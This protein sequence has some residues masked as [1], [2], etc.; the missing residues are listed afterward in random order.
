MDYDL[1]FT[2]REKFNHLNSYLSD[3]TLD[4]VKAFHVTEQ[5]SYKALA[6]W[7][8]VYNN[9]S[10]IFWQL[11]NLSNMTKSQSTALKRMIDT[12]S[13]IYDTLLSI[14]DN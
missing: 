13:A 10:H 4:T 8:R 14:S 5:K 3:E 6:C 12:V 1:S 2:G 9:M 11:F 7:N